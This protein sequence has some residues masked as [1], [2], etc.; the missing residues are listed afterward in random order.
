MTHTPEPTAEDYRAYIR[1][2]RAEHIASELELLPTVDHNGHPMTDDDHF[3]GV[4][5]AAVLDTER[6]NTSTTDTTEHDVEDEHVEADDSAPRPPRP[7]PAQGSSANPPPEPEPPEPGS[8]ERQ[9]WEL[10]KLLD[11]TGLG[12]G[13]R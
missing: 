8:P 10:S 2:H 11:G 13:T 1:T 6:A 9:A 5:D 12:P 3:V 4:I 7:T